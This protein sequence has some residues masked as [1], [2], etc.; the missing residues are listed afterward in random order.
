MG[1]TLFICS[2]VEN[3]SLMRGYICPSVGISLTLCA[4]I[5]R[6]CMEVEIVRLDRSIPNTST[7]IVLY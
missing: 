6:W 1:C 4:I 7:I 5:S 3:L 2:S